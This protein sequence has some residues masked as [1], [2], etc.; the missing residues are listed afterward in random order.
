V[1]LSP[2]PTKRQR[3]LANL[4][5]GARTAPP[6]NRRAVRHGGYASIAA[7]RL[8][9]K[10]HEVYEA[11]AADAPLRDAD[12]ELPRADA[13][14]VRL[15]AEA[16]CRLDSIADYLGRHGWQGDDGAPR[17]AVELE[18]KLRREVADHLDALGMTPR[19]RSRLGV[20]LAR[21]RDLATEWATEGEVDR[22]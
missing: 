4:V 16:L 11:L 6:G 21:S 7:Y 10:V 18:A 8:E 22:G 19:S 2:D 15:L 5:P 3:Q 12:G 9:A 17:P 13:V 1:P 20:D 14:A